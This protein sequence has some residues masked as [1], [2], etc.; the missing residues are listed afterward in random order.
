[1]KTISFSTTIAYKV[2]VGPAILL[3]LLQNWNESY[4]F[5]DDEGGKWTNLT[6]S[7][8]LIAKRMPLFGKNTLRQHLYKL[9]GEKLVTIKRMVA[10][11]YFALNHQ[12][13]REFERKIIVKNPSNC[14]NLGTR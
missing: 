10:V 1:M 3:N 14:L 2:G 4:A 6:H 9:E 12:N 5:E 13:I 8:S 11:L 7:L